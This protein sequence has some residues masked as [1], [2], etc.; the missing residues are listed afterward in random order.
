VRFTCPTCRK[1]LEGTRA[2]VPTLPFCSPRCRAAD[3]G[4]W[5]NESYRIGSPVTEEDLDEGLPQGVR[6]GDD[7]RAGDEK[8]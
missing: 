7:V 6:A 8:N 5:L 2:D 3:L 1:Q 4:N